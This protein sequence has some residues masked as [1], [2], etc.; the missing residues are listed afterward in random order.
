[1]PNDEVTDPA[2]LLV[3]RGLTPRRRRPKTSSP[4]PTCA[5]TFVSHT[6]TGLVVRAHPNS[7]SIC[8]AAEFNQFVILSDGKYYRVDDTA[9]TI[10]ASGAQAWSTV[11]FPHN[12][13]SQR[14]FWSSY[15]EISLQD[16][17]TL[18]SVDPNDW[19]VEDTFG[20]DFYDP[21]GNAI[22][23]NPQFATH[24]TIRE[25]N[26]AGRYRIA[27]PVY[28]TQEFI[29]VEG[30]FA[31]ATAGNTITREGSVELEPG[32]AKSIVAT[33][34]D[35]DVLAGSQVTWNEGVLS[36]SNAEWVNSVVGR[37]VEPSQLWQDHAAPMVRDTADIIADGRPRE[38]SL[39]LRLVR[40]QD[41]ALRVSEVNRR[42]GRLW[43]RGGVKLGPRF[44]E[45]EAGDWIAWQS[46]RR[47]GGGTKTLRIDAYSVDG[48]WQIALTLRETNASVYADD[49]VFGS[50]GS[51]VVPSPPPP[52]I[53]APDSGAWTLTA[54][55][56]VDAG[57]SVPAIVIA[58]ACEDDSASSI[59]FEYWKDDG[60]IDP[61]ANPD[62]PAWVSAGSRAR[63]TTRVEIT[64]IQGAAVYYAAVSYVV[65][66]ST[67][68]RLVLGPV[69]AGSL[70]VS[71]QVPDVVD[72]PTLGSDSTVDVP[73]VHAVRG[74]VAA[75]LLGLSWKLPARTK[76]AAALPA[77][78]YANGASGVG[79]TLTGAANGALPVQGGVALDVG[80]RLIVDQEAVAPHNG[81]YIVSQLGDGAHPYILTRTADADSGT[82]LVSAVLEVSE[83]DYA[84]TQWTCAGDSP[85]TIGA[86]AI[87]FEEPPVGGGSAG[88]TILPLVDGEIPPTFIQNPDGSLIYAEIE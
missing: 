4:P 49:G 62:D 23:C 68:D 75:A 59:I 70:D 7:P 86:S 27:G 3:G 55:M 71:G 65:S 28:S 5:T 30:M 45:L 36:E 52:A 69:T 64:S 61:I 20:A 67:G 56:L 18:R 10:T 19:V 26:S 40:D 35:A 77:N 32:Q 15:S 83:G 73:S 16:G 14:T 6:I 21:I 84:E 87:L 74:Y 88:S 46:D 78:I 33:I 58:G 39:T 12:N 22:W 80:N 37:Y 29:D 44:C 11:N 79:A 8:H 2:A 66:G 82:D 41:Q 38:A 51:V 63:T 25:L 42:L 1:M 48:K 47:F 72:D 43:G 54:V 50:D 76:T 57:A 24:Q 81:I 53:G 13:P 17:S 85:L 31:A 9:F 60:V 34:T